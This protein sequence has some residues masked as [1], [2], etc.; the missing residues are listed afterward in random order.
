MA[1]PENVLPYFKDDIHVGD[2]ISLQSRI[3]LIDGTAPEY[4]YAADYTVC[5]ILESNYIGYSSG[6]LAAILGSG[7][8][9]PVRNRWHG[10]FRI[11]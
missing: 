8:S 1:F 2:T 11:L 5:G 6:M 4:V 10:A 3:S 9:D 7:K